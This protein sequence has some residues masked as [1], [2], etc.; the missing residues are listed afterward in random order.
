V[1]PPSWLVK[2]GAAALGCL[3]SEP[4]LEHAVAQLFDVL[5]GAAGDIEAVADDLLRIAAQVSDAALDSGCDAAEVELR[6]GDI[7]AYLL[8]VQSYWS[9][10]ASK[11]ASWK[12]VRPAAYLAK[13]DIEAAV[14]AA[15]DARDPYTATKLSGTMMRA[16]KALIITSLALLISSL[17]L[18]IIFEEPLVLVSQSAPEPEIEL[19]MEDPYDRLSITLPAFFIS[20]AASAVYMAHFRSLGSSDW[21]EIARL[22][23]EWTTSCLVVFAGAATELWGLWELLE[24]AEAD[25]TDV[26]VFFYFIVWFLFFTAL[27]T[28]VLVARVLMILPAAWRSSLLRWQLFGSMELI[29]PLEIAASSRPWMLRYRLPGNRSLVDFCAT[30]PLS[31]GPGQKFTHV[32]PPMPPPPPARRSW[33]SFGSPPPPPVPPADQPT[34]PEP[35]PA[36][37]PPRVKTPKQQAAVALK[38]ARQK[39]RRRRL[40]KDPTPSMHPRGADKELSK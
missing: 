2:E 5:K 39:D 24:T 11:Y 1:A 21:L 28:V 18:S 32:A 7:A 4:A 16:G 13:E 35:Q 29:V 10:N 19:N 34:T 36:A 9:A 37:A 25:M 31:V 27:F 3:L 26:W 6:I 33:W 20:L 22:A 15:L 12:L 38:R 17:A 40:T 14:R 30:V 8:V 23:P